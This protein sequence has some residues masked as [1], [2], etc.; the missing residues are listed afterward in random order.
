[1]GKCST[2]T[3]TLRLRSLTK[4]SLVI[5]LSGVA[6]PIAFSLLRFVPFPGAL[7]SK[8]NAWVIDPPLFGTKHDTPVLFGLA[9]VPKRGQALFIFYFLV[10]N[11][12][13]SSVNYEYTNPNIWYPDN[14]WRW[15][16]MLVSN[17]L[18]LLSFANLPLVFLYAGRNN[19]LLWVTNWSH[20]TFLLIHRWIAAI[21]TLQAILHSIIYL[22]AYVKAGT[23]ASESKK[24]FWYW[25]AIATIGMSILLPTSVLPIRKRLY[26][27]F[28]AWHVAISVLVVAGCY[29]HILFEYQ[30]QWGYET[31]II[32][33]M[34]VW[35]FDRVF[36]FLRLARH[37]VQRAEVTIVDDEYIRVHVPHVTSS[38]YAYLYFP[39]LT[40]RVWE[41]HPFSVASTM[42][43]ASTNLTAL[44]R[45][46]TDLDIEKHPEILSSSVKGSSNSGR[47]PSDSLRESYRAGITFYIRGKTGITSAIRKR[48]SLPVFLEAGYSAHSPSSLHTSPTLIVLAGGVGITAVLPALQTHPGRAKLYWGCRT[49]AFVDDVKSIGVL[50]HV[51]QEII[52]GRRMAVREILES[53]LIGGATGEIAVLVSGPGGMADEVRNV[54]GDI[55]RKQTGVRVKLVMESFSW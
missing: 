47:S 17:R 31:W 3:L 4:C 29:W 9:Q 21:A 44:D 8:F 45:D 1:M 49:Q 26:E 41:N 10:I 50:S 20:S 22:H 55:V 37:G 30:H 39:T 53:E 51:E 16:V 32:I 19:F 43:P 2:S 40:W 34:A 28:L 48:T 38:G 25:G 35:G 15:M 7:R 54:V 14:K 27:L 24:P 5:L 23:H 11:I 42:L 46:S 36:R 52:V 18:G 12:M 33:V 6:I 13:F